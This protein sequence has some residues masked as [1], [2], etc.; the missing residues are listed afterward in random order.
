LGVFGTVF[1]EFF[2]C[3]KWFFLNCFPRIGKITAQRKQHHRIVWWML[4]GKSWCMFFVVKF[5][6]TPFNSYKTSISRGVDG[7]CGT[8]FPTK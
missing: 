4:A 1:L 5:D 2:F 3:L 7:Y 8:W 6:N